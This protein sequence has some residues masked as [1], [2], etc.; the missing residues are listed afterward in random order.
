MGWPTRVNGMSDDNYIQQIEEL[1]DKKI[2][3]LNERIDMM[4]RHLTGN[5]TPERGIIVR[6]DRIEQR[7]KVIFW[8]LAALSA[9]VISM[10]IDLA[11]SWMTSK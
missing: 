6:L 9:G 5:G 7:A 1:L 11:K 8:G 2:E 4:N 10:F 3:P